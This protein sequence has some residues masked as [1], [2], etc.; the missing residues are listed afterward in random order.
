LTNQS[1]FIAA[2]EDCSTREVLPL[3]K[4]D[5]AVAVKCFTKAEVKMLRNLHDRLYDNADPLA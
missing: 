2:K 5:E 4:H 1:I 3:A